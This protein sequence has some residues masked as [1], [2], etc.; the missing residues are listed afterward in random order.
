MAKSTQSSW[1]T[2]AATM[3]AAAAALAPSAS[4]D[5]GLELRVDNPLVNP[6][7]TV[8]VGLYVVGDPGPPAET[9][10]AVEAI[11]TWDTVHLSL[12]GVDPANPANLIFAGF[13]AVGTG[14]L[15]EANP[16]ADG[17]AIFVGL[18]PLGTPISAD[19]AGSLFA[20]LTFTAAFSTPSTSI[21][22]LASG[23]S[24]VRETV[25]FDGTT[26]NTI[27]T[28]SLTGTSLI[29]RCGPFDTA[30]PYG[31]LDLADVNVFTSG[32]L[33]TDPVADLN[34]D[35]IFDLSDIN[36]FI[37]GFLMGCPLPP[38]P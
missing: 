27:V 32:F 29:I 8:S 4:A 1:W 21:D 19:E 37:D 3:L 14:G 25:V 23:G 2:T 13:P 17:D 5:V 18:G 35:G 9:V 38:G 10:G 6:G 16:P 30:V 36:L 22:L 28:G 11:F 15:N 12:V 34:E 24:P 20:T 26:P 7:D 31:Q 33:A